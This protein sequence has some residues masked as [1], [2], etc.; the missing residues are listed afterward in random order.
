MLDAGTSDWFGNGPAPTFND[1]IVRA[2][3]RTLRHAVHVCPAL[4]GSILRYLKA[5]HNYG[6]PI[7]VAS[8]GYALAAPKLVLMTL[9]EADDARPVSELYWLTTNHAPL[10][11]ELGYTHALNIHLPVLLLVEELAHLLTPEDVTHGPAWREAF[12]GLATCTDLAPA[13]VQRVALMT[14]G[15]V[16][17]PAQML[18]A[19]SRLR[20]AEDAIS[21]AGSGAS[22][23]P[24][25]DPA[26]DRQST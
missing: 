13:D 7:G 17:Q 1:G 3:G 8:G 26:P 10:H 5:G 11:A 25:P 12:M 4:N 2:L 16:E 23:P 6:P 24:R 15:C 9:D 19:L 14:R 20:N 18:A 22:A 21:E